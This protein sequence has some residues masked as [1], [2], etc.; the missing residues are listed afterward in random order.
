MPEI[1]DIEDDV[2]GYCT[3]CRARFGRAQLQALYRHVEA[4]GHTAR[5]RKLR[6]S[7]ISPDG[8]EEEG[9]G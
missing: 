7:E 9:R 6:V 8:G 4:S 5:W 1:R 3:V 2:G